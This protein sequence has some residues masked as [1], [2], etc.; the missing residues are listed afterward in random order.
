MTSPGRHFCVL[1]IF[2]LSPCVLASCNRVR[3]VDGLT[4]FP[5]DH[6]ERDSIS[7]QDTVLELGKFGFIYC[8]GSGLDGYDSLKVDAS[9]QCDYIFGTDYTNWKAATFTLSRSEM[10]ELC[11]T[12]N[13]NK[14]MQLPAAYHAKVADGTQIIV[15]F[16]SNGV[17][18]QIYCNNHFPAEVLSL[19]RLI[20]KK[21]IPR[22]SAEVAKSTS[23]GPGI[24]LEPEFK[25]E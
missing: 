18:K 23:L 22:H 15:K 24:P 17:V 5:I 6:V 19:R 11:D 14:M 20:Q 4:S 25:T 8:E 21:L 10:I 7:S 2:L 1:L 12:I 13:D 16:L 3:D 9:G